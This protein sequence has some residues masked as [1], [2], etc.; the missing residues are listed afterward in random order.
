M[1]AVSADKSTCVK[2][3]LQWRWLETQKFSNASVIDLQKKETARA[4]MRKMEKYLLKKFKYHRLKDPLFLYALAFNKVELLLRYTANSTIA[5]EYE[6][7]SN[8]YSLEQMLVL[9]EKQSSELPEGYRKV[10]RSYC[11]VRDAALADNDTKELIH[12]RVLELQQKKKLTNYRLYTDLKLNPGNVNAWL[13]HNDSSKMSLD[14]ARQI[15]KYAK[16]Y[17]SVR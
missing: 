5:E 8:L 9:L 17:P 13:K 4:S 11:S 3:T 7:L 15:Y 2:R 12:R 1:F 10:W 14:C 6:Q 16:S